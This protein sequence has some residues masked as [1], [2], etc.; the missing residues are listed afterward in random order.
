MKTGG[1]PMLYITGDLHGDP[2]RFQDKF[3][4]TLKKGDSLIVCGDFGFVWDG[5]KQEQSLLKKIGKLKYNVLFLEGTH[6]NLD[7]ISQYPIEQWNGGDVRRIY[8]NLLKLE[9][10]HIFTLEG[11]KLFVFGGGES[12][13]MDE[14]GQAGHW[15]QEELPTLKEIEFGRA[16]LEKYNN[17]VDYI[18]THQIGSKV[19]SFIDMGSDHVNPMTTFFDYIAKNISFK[20]W[21]FGSYH[22]D[23][24]IPP[25]YYALFQNIEI[26][27]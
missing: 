14:R 15:W 22:M 26:L 20:G 11:K 6:D 19:K 23:K 21:Y 10:G 8:G 17:N 7:L 2:A 5:S 27:V 24:V 18:I 12:N 1:T 3:L 4:R 13:D 25:R 16:K 9:R